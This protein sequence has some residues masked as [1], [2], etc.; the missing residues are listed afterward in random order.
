MLSN[1]IAP[2]FGDDKL[3]FFGSDPRVG[4]D[5][6]G[7]YILSVNENVKVYFTDYYN[8]LQQ[9]ELRCLEEKEMLNA[10]LAQTDPKMSESIAYYRARKVVVDVVLKTVYSFYPESSNLAVVMTPWCFGTVVLE[11]VEIYKERLSKGETTDPNIPDFPFF[12]LKYVEEIYKRTLL[13]LFEF[14]EKAFS[15]RWQYTELLKRYSK[16]LSNVTTS[17]QNI[18]SIVKKEKNI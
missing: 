3:R 17:L 9:V 14:P 4:K 11:R 5:E 12:V 15:M 18:L 13:E 16:V 6:G 2:G 8:F 10:K 7:C 1:G